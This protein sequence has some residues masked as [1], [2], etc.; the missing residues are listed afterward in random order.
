MAVKP[1]D[2]DEDTS[3]NDNDIVMKTNSNHAT[4][5]I[6]FSNIWSWIWTKVY[7]KIIS[8]EVTLHAID[9]AKPYQPVDSTA[10]I[11]SA[12]SALDTSNP[13]PVN[14]TAV[15]GALTDY[16]Q[17]KRILFTTYNVDTYGNGSATIDLSN[18]QSAYILNITLGGNSNKST[19]ITFIHPQNI[20]GDDSIMQLIASP[21]ES[22]AILDSYSFSNSILSL[23]LKAAYT[24]VIDII[25]F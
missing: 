11:N 1:E 7:N 8:S 18:F 13:A 3:P 20:W 22:V 2:L 9:E 15:N 17:K 21:D 10:V 14:S 6:K 5:T 25:F 24:G 16:A 12:I 19:A 4:R 23:K